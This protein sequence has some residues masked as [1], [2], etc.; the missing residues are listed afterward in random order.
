MSSQ[1]PFTFYDPATGLVSATMAGTRVT[2]WFR[3]GPG[4]KVSFQ[5]EWDGNVT[6]TWSVEGTN[7]RAPTDGVAKGA[8]GTAIDTYPTSAYSAPSQPAGSA[9]STTIYFEAANSYHRGT[10]ANSAGGTAV[11]PSGTAETP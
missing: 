5:F 7:R 6:G 9:G 10:F 11:V 3:T 2:Q 1:T 4:A 8:A